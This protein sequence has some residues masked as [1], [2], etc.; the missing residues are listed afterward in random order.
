MRNLTA[1][2]AGEITAYLAV[3]CEPGVTPFVD[4]ADPPHR[5][6]Q[7][8]PEVRSLQQTARNQGYRGGFLRKHGAGF[9]YQQGLDAVAFGVG[10]VCSNSSTRDRAT[11]GPPRRQHQRKDPNPG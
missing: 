6:D 5:A 11:P 3:F 2:P 9:Y 10:G 4:Y 7:N 1:S 8:R